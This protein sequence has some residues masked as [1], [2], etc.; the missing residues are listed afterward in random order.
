MSVSGL[1]TKNRR[2]LKFGSKEIVYGRYN[3]WKFESRM[4]YNEAMESRRKITLG[5]NISAACV[6]CRYDFEAKKWSLARKA[7]TTKNITVKNEML[8]LRTKV[9]R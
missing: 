5:K 6:T 3:K 7:Q 9:I 4:P 2:K 1:R 8:E